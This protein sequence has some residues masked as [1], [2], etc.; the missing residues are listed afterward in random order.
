MRARPNRTFRAGFRA[1]RLKF[2]NEI[3][4]NRNLLMRR[5]LPAVLLI[6]PGLAAAQD[7]ERFF[8]TRIRPVLIEKCFKCHHGE[9]A[10]GGLRLDSLAVMLSDNYW[11]RDTLFAQRQG[12]LPAQNS[13]G[14]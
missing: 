14:T 11:S 2:A 7:T 12:I 8:E 4:G 1:V 10:K 6:C 5:F 13:S 9:K 3:T